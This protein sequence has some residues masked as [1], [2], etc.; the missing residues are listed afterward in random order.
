VLREG[1]EEGGDPIAH[2]HRRMLRAGR[3]LWCGEVKLT[4]LRELDLPPETLLE[5]ARQIGASIVIL[6]RRNYL[7]RII[8]SLIVKQT[9]RYHLP[10]SQ[11]RELQPFAL[12]VN[13]VTHHGVS[14]SLLDHLRHLEDNCQAL[15]EFA[16]RDT[17]LHL[18]YEQDVE[19]DPTVAYEKLCRLMGLPPYRVK[20]RL[21][22][23]N[24][25]ELSRLIVNYDQLQAHLDGTPYDW[26]LES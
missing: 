17:R 2:F 15:R 10:A 12:D 9:R 20:V 3:L 16:A 7:R 14:M 18:T 6:E 4:H 21:G 1:V 24:S 25:C 26:M 23:V 13:Q 19:S 11:R 5:E 8:S 22:R